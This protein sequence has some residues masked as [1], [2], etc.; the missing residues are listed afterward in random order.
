MR[1]KKFFLVS[2]INTVSPLHS[3][4]IEE[5]DLETSEERLYSCIAGKKADAQ[6]SQDVCPN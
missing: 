6:R 3:L 5:G 4:L 1:N 2:R